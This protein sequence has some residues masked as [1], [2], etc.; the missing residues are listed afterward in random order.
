MLGIVGIT[1]KTTG[2][3]LHFEV[4]IETNSFYAT[5]NPE[6][7]LAPPQGWGVLVGRLSNTNGSHL[8][9]Q[10]VWVRSLETGQ[11]WKIISYGEKIVIRDDYYQENLVLSDLPAG[12]YQVAIDYQE[13]ELLQAELT[14]HPGAITYFT[15]RGK[16]GF[17]TSLPPTPS[18]EEWFVS[19]HPDP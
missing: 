19:V 3:H 13:E 18:P 1:G 2:P 9:K 10:T 4:R 16:W 14:I 15:F 8:N 7:W 5:R 12:E 6:L 11:K 17:N